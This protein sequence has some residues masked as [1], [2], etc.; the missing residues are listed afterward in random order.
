MDGDRSFFT[1][2]PLF[3]YKII[4]L[5][6]ILPQ[7]EVVPYVKTEVDAVT[8]QQSGIGPAIGH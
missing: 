1:G 3:D 6:P 8:N 5:N 7:L 2:L 4:R